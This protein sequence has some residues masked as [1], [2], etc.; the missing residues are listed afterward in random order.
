MG[1]IKNLDDRIDE[2]YHENIYQTILGG[3]VMNMSF[4]IMEVKYDAIDTDDSSC[5]DYYIINFSS[6][7]YTLQADL[8]IDGQVISSGNCM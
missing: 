1:L 5:R 3:N 4:I 8:I 2:E 6:Y 7:P